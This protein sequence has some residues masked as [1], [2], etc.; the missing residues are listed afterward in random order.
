[1]TG[2]EEE[3]VGIAEIDEI[4]EGMQGQLTIMM[5]LEV[6]EQVNN[7]LLRQICEERTTAKA[8]EGGEAMCKEAADNN[9][10]AEEVVVGGDI[11]VQEQGFLC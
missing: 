5:A 8:G 4:K 6:A 7:L 1:M 10:T 3:E 11:D 2:G 9:M